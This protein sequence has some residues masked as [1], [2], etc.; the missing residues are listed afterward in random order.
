MM[1]WQS[2][3]WI[4]ISGLI[5]AISHSVL[6]TKYCKHWIYPYGCSEQRYR[7]LYSIFA[8]ISTG[9]WILF[10]HGLPDIPLYQTHGLLWLTLVS[11]Q[12]LGGSIALAALLPID[13]LAFLGLRGSKGG[14]DPFIIRGIYRHIRHPMYSGVMLILLAMPEQSSNGLH[15]TLLV[16]LYFIIGARFEETRMLA[17]HPD[18]ADYRRR[19][20]AFIPGTKGF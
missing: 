4:W 12:T 8:V 11:L 16:C 1:E 18:Y 14:V 20:A 17:S 2:A 6:A 15:F 9:L 10:L 5:F 7:L 3:V 13:G 19:V